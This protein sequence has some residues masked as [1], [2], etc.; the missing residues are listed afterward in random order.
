MPIAPVPRSPIRKLVFHKLVS[1]DEIIFRQITEFLKR[2]YTQILIDDVSKL[3]YNF[4]YFI[5]NND[6]SA[7]NLSCLSTFYNDCVDELIHELAY[8]YNPLQIYDLT[9]NSTL[10]HALNL[11][12]S[13]VDELEIA[14]YHRLSSTNQDSSIIQYASKY[15]FENRSSDSIGVVE[16]FKITVTDERESWMFSPDMR[17]EWIFS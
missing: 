3:N 8:V 17:E 5:S 15:S 7:N 14:V 10:L 2:N 12:H 9:D 13:S 4:S 1:N 16:I 6:L 11:A